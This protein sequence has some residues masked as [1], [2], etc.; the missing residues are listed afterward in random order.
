[1][2]EQ[3]RERE[4][5]LPLLRVAP[6]YSY[7][8]LQQFQTYVSAQ[9]AANGKHQVKAKHAYLLQDCQWVGRVGDIQEA[10]NVGN[11]SYI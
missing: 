1:M 11:I 5:N 7:L 4:K 2:Q 3:A 6:V 9:R 10:E 8:L